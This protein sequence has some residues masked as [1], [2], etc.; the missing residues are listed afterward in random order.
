MLGV[1]HADLR[2]VGSDTHQCRVT[3]VG[4]R[5]S[6]KVCTLTNNDDEQ[7]LIRSFGGGFI[8]MNG[9]M[10]GEAGQLLCNGDR[11]AIFRA[12]IFQVHTRNRKMVLWRIST[13]AGIQKAM[14]FV[15]SDF[16]IAVANQLLEQAQE[17]SKAIVIANFVLQVD[18]VSFQEIGSCMVRSMRLIHT[19]KVLT[20]S[21]RVSETARSENSVVEGTEERVLSSHTETSC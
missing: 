21:T 6:S 8:R 16:G 20:V 10:V 1:R 3:L 5:I 11:L 12:Y 7:H 2:V 14:L 18:G 17:A 13:R 19:K 9:C 4:I 15:K